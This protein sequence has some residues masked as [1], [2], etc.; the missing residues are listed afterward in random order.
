MI[1]SYIAPEHNIEPF[2]TSVAW[3]S[4]DAMTAKE[5]SEVNLNK[6]QTDNALSQ[7]GAIDAVDIRK[8][9][10]ND[11]ESGYNGLIAEED[12]PQPEI[13]DEYPTDEPGTPPPKEENPDEDK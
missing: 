1:R 12:V 8:R 3:N 9:I 6:A 7:A 2:E 10:V 4:L 13:E 5:Q 11:K